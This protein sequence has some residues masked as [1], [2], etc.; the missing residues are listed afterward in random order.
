MQIYDDP[1]STYIQKQDIT[2]EQ[3]YLAFNH[4]MYNCE[5]GDDMKEENDGMLVL[6]IGTNK[7]PP[8]GS[9]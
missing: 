1:F 8:V 6:R 4:G 2:V 9:M 5:S 3:R 7:Y